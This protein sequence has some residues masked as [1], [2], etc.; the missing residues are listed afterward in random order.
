MLFLGHENITHGLGIEAWPGDRG[1]TWGHRHGLGTKSVPK[2]NN[3]SCHHSTETHA[4]FDLHVQSYAECTVAASVQGGHFALSF[5]TMQSTVIARYEKK[6]QI[7]F[8]LHQ[9]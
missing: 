5:S 8:S 2:Y 3:L 6:K 9:K 4:D 7:H 1:M